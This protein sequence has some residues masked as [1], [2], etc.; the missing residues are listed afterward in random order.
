MS[1][2][3]VRIL[4]GSRLK[5]PPECP[6]TG[7]KNPRHSVLVTRSENQMWLPIPFVGWFSLGK[8]GQTSFPA[9]AV[10]AWV[11]SLLT[12]LFWLLLVGGFAVGFMKKDNFHAAD[13]VLGGVAGS[14]LIRILRWLW[15]R[16]VRIV[17][18]GMSSLEVRFASEKYAREFSRLNDFSCREHPSQK[19]VTPITVNDVR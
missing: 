15:L 11:A 4:F 10:V 1:A 14:I 13:Y 12:F 19:R 5:F 8:T 7:G 17:R 9:S 3:Y 6:F 2:R 16:R 18:I